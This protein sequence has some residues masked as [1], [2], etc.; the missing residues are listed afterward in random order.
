MKELNEKLE[1][2]GWQNLTLLDNWIQ[3]SGQN[4]PQYRKKNGIVYLHGVV[5][6]SGG[7]N[8]ENRN[9]AQLPEGFI[10]DGI[11][12]NLYYTVRMISGSTGTIGHLQ[13]TKEGI[14]LGALGMSSNDWMT[15]DGISFPVE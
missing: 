10:P 3:Y 12:N 11:V 5:R 1:D 6:T 2:S 7:T 4:P 9:I 13:I 15:L 14:L 8:S